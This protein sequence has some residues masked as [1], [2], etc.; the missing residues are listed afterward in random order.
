[1]CKYILL[2]KKE[3]KKKNQIKKCDKDIEDIYY[4]YFFV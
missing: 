4:I 2:E 1:M 3:R